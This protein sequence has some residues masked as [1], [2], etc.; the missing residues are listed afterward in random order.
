MTVGAAMRSGGMVAASLAAFFVC[1]AQASAQTP[2]ALTADDLARAARAVATFKPKDRFDPPPSVADLA[3]RTF[4]VA[5]PLHD[6][7]VARYGQPT[8]GF[9]AYDPA[10]GELHVSGSAD[11]FSSGIGLVG[12]EQGPRSAQGFVFR[13]AAVPGKSYSAQNS[14]GARASITPYT[15]AAFGVA[16]FSERFTTRT[17]PERGRYDLTLTARPAEARALTAHL[18][19]VVEGELTP[20]SG[21]RLIRCGDDYIAATVRNPASVS[22]RTCVFSA[23]VRR[24][25]LTRTDTNELLRS[26]DA[27]DRPAP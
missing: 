21:G 17:L 24:V 6:G 9:W 8:T 16:E 2:A 10:T 12:V 23:R 20:D 27:S 19:L 4:R 7:N 13:A 18:A 1:A 3:G 25:S 5:I 22:T 14:Y 11:D 26:W 15:G